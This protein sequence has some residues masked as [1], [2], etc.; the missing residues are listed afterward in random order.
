[1]KI[2]TKQGDK[3][4]TELYPGKRV[5][6]SSEEIM[7]LGAIDELNCVLGEVRALSK[8]K[9]TLLILKKIQN[10]LFKMGAE[11]AGRKKVL[12]EK[13]ILFLE[14][15]IESL[16]KKL[17]EL[18]RFILPDGCLGA[19][20]LHTARAVCRRAE[21]LT[22]KI[23]IKEKN[24]LIPYLNRL[25]DLLFLLARYENFKK[26]IKDETVII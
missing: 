5:L 2:S 24:I 16:E 17:P 6:K 26:G 3:G 22:V 1:M 13:D 4:M 9:S 10:D 23:K 11:I 19:A 12:T 8:I 7:C 25:S 21:R 14:E 15:N 18:K 20:K